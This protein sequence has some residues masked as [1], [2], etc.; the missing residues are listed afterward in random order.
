MDV[1]PG[2]GEDRREAEQRQHPSPSAH[3]LPKSSPDIKVTDE[4]MELGRGAGRQL[5]L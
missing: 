4:A 1:R 3:H 5:P 2:L